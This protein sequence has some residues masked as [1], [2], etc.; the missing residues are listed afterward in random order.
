MY[1]TLLLLPIIIMFIKFI[2]FKIMISPP[3]PPPPPQKKKKIIIIRKRLNNE[4]IIPYL[5]VKSL[6]RKFYCDEYTSESQLKKQKIE[7]IYPIIEKTIY[8]DISSI[9]NFKCGPSK[10]LNDIDVIL[11]L[12]VDLTLLHCEVEDKILKVTL[13]PYVKEFIVSLSQKYHIGIFTAGTSSYVKY[14]INSFFPELKILFKFVFSREDCLQQDTDLYI[15]NFSYLLKKNNYKYKGLSKYK[16][17]Y[18]IDDNPQNIIPQSSGIRIKPFLS[19]NYEEE[20]ENRYLENF[21]IN[22]INFK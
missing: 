11:F 5:K 14:I 6:K 17:I 19:D 4:K 15:K 9:I 8:Q 13:R 2:V 22:C 21:I 3:P 16:N 1:A 12:D 20:K 18:L 10:D 7:H